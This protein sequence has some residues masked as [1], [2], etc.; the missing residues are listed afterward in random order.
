MRASLMHRRLSYR[1]LTHLVTV[2]RRGNVL[3]V[4]LTGSFDTILCLSV[5]KWVHLN[6]GDDGLKRLFSRAF[7][8]LVPGGLLIVEP[9]PWKSYSA[10]FHKQKMPDETRVHYRNVA[11]RPAEFAEHLHSVVGFARVE[12]LREGAQTGFDRPLLV[13]YK[14]T[15]V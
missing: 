4:P 5:T 10:A 13:C 1:P 12:Q 11:L 2:C 7:D 8:L 14:P 6:W 15:A 3:D 9:Q